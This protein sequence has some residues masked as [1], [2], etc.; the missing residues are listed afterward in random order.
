MTIEEIL[1]KELNQLKSDV[2][3]RHEQAGQVASGKTRSS[4]VVDTQGR[5]GQLSGNAYVGVLEQG[6]RGGKVPADFIDILK[7]W[8][9][10]KGISF[11]N[12]RQFNTWAYFV[13]KKIMKEGTK[14]YRSG[15]KQ[16][17]FTTP[18]REMSERLSEKVGAYY[19]VQIENEIFK[20]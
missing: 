8:A 13:K 4:F 14:L 15:T 19:K 16:D 2:I 1:S 3:E 17:I 10:A 12:E 6:R 20:F 9:T 5:R 18:I 7:R 11:S